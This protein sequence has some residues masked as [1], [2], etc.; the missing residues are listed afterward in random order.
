[1]SEVNAVSKVVFLDFDGV[2][3]TPLKNPEGRQYYL[4]P[5]DGEVS[6]REA[7][8]YVQ[9][10]CLSRG[11]DIVVSSS[12]RGFCDCE[13]CLRKAGLSP[14]VKVI[15]ETPHPS[16]VLCGMKG[17]RTHEISAWLA[18][19]PEVEIFLIFDDCPSGIEWY[20]GHIVTCNWQT[21][22][23]EKEYKEALE[24][25]RFFEELCPKRFRRR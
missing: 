15:G 3:N 4:G 20:A 12:W 13:A 25:D 24:A 17:A 23:G 8:R 18:E 11:Y 9:D 7:V 6:N 2:V 19:H 1:M 21:G 5:P 16:D 14:E 10:F 22:F